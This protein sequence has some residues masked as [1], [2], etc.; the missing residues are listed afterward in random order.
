MQELDD[1]EIICYY[2]KIYMPQSLCRRVLDWYHFY[3]NH[4]GGSKLSKKIREICY[5]KGLVAQAELFAKT[6]NICQQSK[7]R[8]TV[9]GHL[10]PKNISEL[11][12]WD[13][14]HVDL[15]VPY[16]KSIR[17]HQTG[18]TVIRKNASL[19]CMEMISR[20]SSHSRYRS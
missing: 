14:V 3:L 16:R 17:Q 13:T 2:S 12:L 19:N 1:I 11:K 4:P 6:F 7:K 10:L 8:K 9:Y 20:R 15:I 18:G 5:W